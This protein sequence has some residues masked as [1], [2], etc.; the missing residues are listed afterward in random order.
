MFRPSPYSDEISL[1]K[2]LLSFD[3]TL[4]I[5]IFLI[6]IISCFSMYSTDGGKFDYHTKSHILR[7]GIFFLMFL[8]FWWQMKRF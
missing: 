7:F 3:Y 2:K 1:F 4:L 6:G 5:C 8:I